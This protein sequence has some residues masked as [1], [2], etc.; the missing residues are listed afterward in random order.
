M[1]LGTSCSALTFL[2]L[3]HCCRIACVLGHKVSYILLDIT[4]LVTD[5]IDCI[6]V[7]FFISRECKTVFGSKA[8]QLVCLLWTAV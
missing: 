3:L 8:Q 5:V 7:L 2:L 6:V 1:R 4:I